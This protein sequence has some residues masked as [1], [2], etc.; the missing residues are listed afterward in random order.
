MSIAGLSTAIAQQNVATQVGM[1][2]LKESQ[3][4]QQAVAEMLDAALQ[5]AVQIQEA[6]QAAVQNGHV[7]TYA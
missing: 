5:S 3:E 2:V 6:G 7:D 4:Q 1:Y